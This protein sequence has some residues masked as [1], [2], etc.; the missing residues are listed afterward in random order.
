[1]KCGF[2]IDYTVSTESI[3][4]FGFRFQYRHKPKLCFR[5][6][7]NLRPLFQFAPFHICYFFYIS[8]QNSVSR[9]DGSRFHQHTIPVRIWLTKSHSLAYWKIKYNW[10]AHQLVSRIFW[11]YESTKLNVVIYIHCTVHKN[12]KKNQFSQNQTA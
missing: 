9:A 2:G 4:Q 7:T 6:Y 11:H 10:S 3:S 5:L 12:E 8:V 1:M